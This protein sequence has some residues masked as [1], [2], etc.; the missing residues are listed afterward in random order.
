MC[1]ARGQ[2]GEAMIGQPN[3]DRF[4]QRG[5]FERR[6]GVKVLLLLPECHVCGWEVHPEF[7]REWNGKDVCKYCIREL[8]EEAEQI[9]LHN[10]D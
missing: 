6:W 1:R 4:S 2:A 10:H 9:E 3:L 7:L 8:E 5:P